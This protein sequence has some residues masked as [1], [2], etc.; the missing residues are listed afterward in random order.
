[1]MVLALRRAV[2]GETPTS[3]GAVV[4]IVLLGLFAAVIGVTAAMRT[5]SRDR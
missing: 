2:T 3:A 4:V 5:R 1:V